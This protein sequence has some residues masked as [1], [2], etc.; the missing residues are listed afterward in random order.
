MKLGHICLNLYGVN[1]AMPT[2]EV[3][4]QL[5]ERY[6]GQVPDANYHAARDYAERIY[7]T[8]KE[9]PA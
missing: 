3:L 7:S 5:V 2:R 1:W 4:D 8:H 9:G 6:L